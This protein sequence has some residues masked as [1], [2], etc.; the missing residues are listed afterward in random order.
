VATA[1]GDVHPKAVQPHNMPEHGASPEVEGVLRA[2]GQ[3]LDATTRAF[4]EPRFGH[5]FSRVRVHADATATKSAQAINALAYTVGREV[6]FASGQYA[7]A[8]TAG[9]RLLAH[10]LA[11]VV[12]QEARQAAGRGAMGG[13]LTDESEATLEREAET[14]SSALATE[15][16]AAHGGLREWLVKIIGVRM[17]R[18]SA[19]SGKRTRPSSRKRTEGSGCSAS[20]VVQ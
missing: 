11:H 4:F 2:T 20:L 9:R 15:G 18:R 1:Q 12:Q 8:T 3:P 10:E 6:I 14:A 16:V 13:L 17:R 19:A 7:P 5:D